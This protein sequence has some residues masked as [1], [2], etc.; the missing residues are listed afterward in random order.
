MSLREKRE[1][2]VPLRLRVGQACPQVDVLR[3]HV[4][5]RDVLAL[6]LADLGQLVDRA[7][8]MRGGDHEVDYSRADLAVLNLTCWV[9]LGVGTGDVAALELD[10]VADLRELGI[11]RAG[12]DGDRQ[13]RLTDDRWA[14]ESWNR[15]A[16]QC[17]ASGGAVGQPGALRRLRGIRAAARDRRL[18]AEAR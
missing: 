2:R 10:Q 1:H 5:S 4:G 14:L 9:G 11:E 16:R 13:L 15:G 7:V 6:D 18:F 8:E 3:A 12:S 17:G